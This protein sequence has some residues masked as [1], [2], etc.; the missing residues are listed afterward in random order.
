MRRDVLEAEAAVVKMQGHLRHQVLATVPWNNTIAARMDLARVVGIRA[1]FEDKPIHRGM[2]LEE[3]S[4][5]EAARVSVSDSL[6]VESARD[7]WV[8]VKEPDT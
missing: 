7:T 3:A 5:S 6:A 2:L 8:A 1:V 4:E